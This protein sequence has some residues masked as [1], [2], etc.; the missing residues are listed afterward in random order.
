MIGRIL[1]ILG[2]LLMVPLVSQAK[3]LSRKVSKNQVVTQEVLLKPGFATMIE[4]PSEIDS[5]ILSDKTLFT[6]SKIYPNN[7]LTCKPLTEI[8][9]S[10]NLIVTTADNEFNL[11]L[12]IASNETN[13]Y[14]KYAFENRETPKKIAVSPVNGEAQKPSGDTLN[15]LLY[16]FKYEKCWSKTSNEYLEFSCLEKVTLG[17]ETFLK[18][19]LKGKSRTPFSILNV[20]YIVKTFGGFTGLKLKDS[21]TIAAEYLLPH[22]NLSFQ[23]EV[24]GIVKVPSISLRKNQKSFLTISTDMGRDADLKEVKVDL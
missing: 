13:I 3:V 8:P 15:R 7:R 18:F 19:V 14:F 16:D 21:R 23:S 22:K 5:Y 1:L 17:H 6:C 11:I 9:L 10:T 4:V 2:F 20:N 12:R 24:R